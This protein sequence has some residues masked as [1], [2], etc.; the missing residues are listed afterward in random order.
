MKFKYET[1]VG[2]VLNSKNQILLGRCQSD[3]ERNGFLCLPGG[4]IDNSEDV[5][6]AALREIK[7][8]TNVTGAISMMTFLTHAGLPTIAFVVMKDTGDNSELKFNDEYDPSNPGGWF[9]LKNLPTEEILNSNLDILKTLGMIKKDVSYHKNNESIKNLIE[10]G[11][12]SSAIVSKI[13]EGAMFNGKYC[14][15]MEHDDG[16]IRS[17]IGGWATKGK[18]GDNWKLW[19]AGR[20]YGSVSLLKSGNI[21]KKAKYMKEIQDKHGCSGVGKLTEEQFAEGIREYLNF[22]KKAQK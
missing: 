15:Y 21:L 8:E 12:D 22:Y 3:D 13:T 17:D 16:D 11:E 9:D 6:T 7:E 19:C 18:G 2:V 1:A 20:S 14:F 5:F 10:S 4:G